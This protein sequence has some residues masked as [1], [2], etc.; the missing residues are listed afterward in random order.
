METLTARRAE[1]SKYDPKQP[2][3]HSKQT[4]QP[5]EEFLMES[6]GSAF[7]DN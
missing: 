1:K 6:F 7:Q 5:C 3:E 2:S 4:L